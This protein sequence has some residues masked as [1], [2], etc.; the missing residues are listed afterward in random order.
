MELTLNTATFG[1]VIPRYLPTLKPGDQVTAKV[2]KRIQAFRYLVKMRGQAIEVNSSILLNAN[3]LILIELQKTKPRLVFTF[4]EKL[5]E[6]FSGKNPSQF[7]NI[8][9]LGS[10][11]LAALF[12]NW[13]IKL[14]LPLRK[15]EFRAVKKFYGVNGKAKEAPA[16]F[17]LSYFWKQLNF[18]EDLFDDPFFV[19]RLFYEDQFPEEQ[20]KLLTRQKSGPGS[21]L[22]TLPILTEIFDSFLQEFYTF[23]PAKILSSIEDKIQKIAENESRGNGKDGA[24]GTEDTEW[25]VDLTSAF[26]NLIKFFNQQQKNLQKGQWI[27]FPLNSAGYNK[28][29]LAY[30]R[31]TKGSRKSESEFLFMVPSKSFG[32]IGVN[33]IINK[34][35]IF[36][37]II[38][39]HQ[40]LQKMVDTYNFILQEKIE[41][42]ELKI[43]NIDFVVEDDL[44]SPAGK[45]VLCDVESNFEVFI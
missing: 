44:L 39:S 22:K 1:E 2:L 34:G 3:D 11:P 41:R 28:K 30:F 18:P 25:G 24:L 8:L 32:E 19:L 35:D 37:K 20:K 29:F 40:G 12:G 5:P 23:D 21:S 38:N 42:I 15:S 7:G 43:K 14:G 45:I 36:L 13:A 33:G 10:H 27:A 4:L 26:R 6:A 16:S 17:L 31:K 9:R